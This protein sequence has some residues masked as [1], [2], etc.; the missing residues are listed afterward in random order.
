[1]RSDR[2][3]GELRKREKVCLLK[4]LPVSAKKRNCLNNKPINTTANIKYLFI[5]KN[6]PT[7][8]LVSIQGRGF[9]FN[10]GSFCNK[11]ETD[12]SFGETQP[13]IGTNLYLLNI[14]K[15]ASTPRNV[16]ICS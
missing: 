10:I 4:H 6:Q 15:Y 7:C 9:C 2:E 11:V 3:L 1:M 8:T 13:D 12:S 14:N 16:R 5:F